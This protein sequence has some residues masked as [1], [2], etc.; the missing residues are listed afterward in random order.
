[1]DAPRSTYI[2]PLSSSA[3]TGVPLMQ[4]LSV[5][6]DCYVLVSISEVAATAK[7]EAYPK[8]ENASVVVGCIFLVNPC[9]TVVQFV[10]FGAKSG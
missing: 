10:E 5:L 3:N 4:T 2:C 6:L 9:H 8:S 7:A 1:M